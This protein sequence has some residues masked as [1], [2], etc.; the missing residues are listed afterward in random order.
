M[1]ESM[2]AVSDGKEVAKDLEIA[3]NKIIKRYNRINE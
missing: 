2:E 3:S 1:V